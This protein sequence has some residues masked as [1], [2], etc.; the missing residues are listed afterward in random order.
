MG[1]PESVP[2]IPDDYKYGSSDYPRT[3]QPREKG[4]FV[5]IEEVAEQV[6][7][8]SSVDI[9][10]EE[11]K[12]GLLDITPEEI[13]EADKRIAERKLREEM[14]KGN[15]QEIP[16][17]KKAAITKGVGRTVGEVKEN[18]LRKMNRT[19]ERRGKEERGKR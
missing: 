17:V 4:G 16:V 10:E 11:T 9:D 1:K 6:E 13:E 2:F 7:D 5:P 18:L 19:P 12:E 15:P 3:N 8:G 14:E